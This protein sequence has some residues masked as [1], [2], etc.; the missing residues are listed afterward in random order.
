[1]TDKISV[2]RG[3]WRLTPKKSGAAVLVL[4]LAAALFDGVSVGLVL[5]FLSLV[6]S[7]A[8]A[9][10]E[11]RML[12]AVVAGMQRFGI[13]FTLGS[14]LSII[15]VAVLL[16]TVAQLIG[17]IHL[18]R[19]IERILVRLRVKLVDNLLRVAPRYH[20]STQAG[21]LAQA[22]MDDV[23]KTGLAIGLAF[24][25][26]SGLSL[27]AVWVAIM[28]IFSWRLTVLALLVALFMTVLVRL[29]IA[30]STRLGEQIAGTKRRLNGALVELLGGLR[31]IWLSTTEAREIERVR[32]ES[33]QLAD[34]T[35]KFQRNAAIVNA[36]GENVGTAAL[37]GILFISVVK[38]NVG[39]AALVAFFFVL[40]RVLPLAHRMNVLRTEFAGHRGHV[41]NVLQLVSREDKPYIVDGTEPVDRMV[42]DVSLHDV[43]FEHRPG[44]PV[45]RGI[46]M[47]I[48][49]GQTVALAGGSG[50]G[51]STIVD[52]IARFADPARGEL[53]VDGRPLRSL[54]LAAWRARLG[55]VSQDVFLFRDTIAGNISYG[56]PGLTRGDIERAARMANAHEFI[57][58]LPQGYDTMVGERGLS[59]S[60]GQ[61]QRIALARTLARQPDLLI[62]DEA[63]SA[64]DAE[65]EHL[66]L[67]AIDRLSG[68]I[69]I[70]VIGH[71]LA[72]LR[73]A[74]VIH[75]VEAGQIVESGTHEQL[76]AARGQYARYCELQ[77]V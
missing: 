60:G 56:T 16:R 39:M 50:G 3:L 70:L 32:S 30:Y 11:H 67:N 75:V 2:W 65:S 53:R 4:Y 71:R 28:L 68:T 8:Q 5:P 25:L 58:S 57:E 76:L 61:R 17:S 9:L 31:V 74:D 21:E 18:V 13:P 62:L 15:G 24:K 34:A 54:Q 38:F 47:T 20:G 49:R 19:V 51:K 55:I 43:W 23:E 73:H 1:M 22:V 36:V 37:L 64:L 72:T 12:G 52:L 59:L 41:A 40:S 14:L 35:N 27:L 46:T 69:A 77:K 44:E 7:N 6:G 45:L 10:S 26:F 63:T 48:P 66:I 29:R 33:T 42:R